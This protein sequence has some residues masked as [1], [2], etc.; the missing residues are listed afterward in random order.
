MESQPAQDDTAA[1]AM[2]PMREVGPVPVRGPEVN[3]DVMVPLASYESPVWPSTQRGARV[4]SLSGGITT[5]IIDERMTRSIALEAPSV[6]DAAEIAA[7]LDH[8]F[9][10]LKAAAARQRR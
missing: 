10:E 9:D 8:R 1:H 6:A 3:D 4:C 7:G 2:V 5:V